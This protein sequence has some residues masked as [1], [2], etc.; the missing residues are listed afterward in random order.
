MEN[1]LLLTDHKGGKECWQAKRSTSTHWRCNISRTQDTTQPT[2]PPG[3]LGTTGVTPD[4]Q[5]R[6][7]VRRSSR[8]RRP[9]FWH[10]EYLMNFYGKGDAT[11]GTYSICDI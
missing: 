1:F 5:P 3:S 7:R 8:F 11:T 9:P 4:I 6:G 2:P 10:S